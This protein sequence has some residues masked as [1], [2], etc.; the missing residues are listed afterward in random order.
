[1]VDMASKTISITEEIYNRLITLKGKNESFSQLFNRMISLYQ[2]NLN[3][4]FG[5]WEMSEEEYIE[6][7]GNIAN[8]PGRKWTHSH[9]TI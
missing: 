1:M 7:W 3:E 6:I 4:S 8:R 2:K 9:S 5:A